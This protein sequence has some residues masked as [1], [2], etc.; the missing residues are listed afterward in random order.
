MKDINKQKAITLFSHLANI[1]FNYAA[2]T[3]QELVNNFNR[4][5]QDTEDNIVLKTINDLWDCSWEMAWGPA[6]NI[7]HNLNVLSNKFHSNNSLFVVKGIDPDTQKKVYVVAV[8]GTN[9]LSIFEQLVEDISVGLLIPWNPQK[10]ECG[11]LSYGSHIGF[12]HVYLTPFQYNKEQNTLKEFFELEMNTHGGNM[13]IITCGHSLGGALSPLIAVALKE[14]AKQKG[15]QETLNVSTYPTA[16]PTPGDGTFA[17]YAE[18]TLGKGNIVSLINTNDIVPLAWEHETLISI[19][20]LYNNNEFGNFTSN[21]INK[22]IDA[23]ALITKD[24]NYTRL[25]KDNEQTFAGKPYKEDPKNS[26][27]EAL[28][29]NLDVEQTTAGKQNPKKPKSFMDVALYQHLKVYLPEGFGFDEEL[30]Q[31]IGEFLESGRPEQKTV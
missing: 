11:K 13:E 17:T 3:K 12:N 8:A 18:N 6:Q 23:F 25:A 30:A 1:N 14:L 7:K 4:I 19:P 20:N 27:D 16:G 21:D 29:Q 28:Y 31:K 9:G 5:L 22:A 10:A 24:L 2:H 15:L 26:K